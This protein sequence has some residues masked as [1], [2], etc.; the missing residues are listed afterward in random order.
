MQCRGP[1]E[2]P[3]LLFGLVGGRKSGNYAMQEGDGGAC[4][5]F[6]T[7][8]R[9]KKAACI[10]LWTGWRE[11]ARGTVLE[12]CFFE[13]HPLG[14]KSIQFGF[15]RGE[16]GSVAALL[17]IVEAE[18]LHGFDDRAHGLAEL[19]QSILHAGRHLG[20]DGP[21][22]E[23]VL[24]HGA[25]AVGQDFLA[26]ALEGFAEL[27][28]AP[29]AGEKVAEDEK[30]PFASDELDSGCNRAF[31]KFV[32]CFHFQI[33]SYGKISFKKNITIESLCNI[34]CGMCRVKRLQKGNYLIKLC[35]LVGSAGKKYT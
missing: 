30:L 25:E 15:L 19:A 20:V 22:D 3:A 4:I 28:E 26:D 8:S 2:V 17:L 24:L 21:R 16:G 10:A 27:V 14:D 29:G 33:L 7:G 13:N 32:F 6:L 18:A 12:I 5:A 11:Q 1:M 23:A 35:V 31:R 9:G 34:P